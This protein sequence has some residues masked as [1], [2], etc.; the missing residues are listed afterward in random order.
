MVVDR[1]HRPHLLGTRG[2]EHRLVGIG[3]EGAPAA[4]VAHRPPELPRGRP[5]AGLHADRVPDAVGVR[6]REVA[7]GGRR[8]R[9]EAHPFQSDRLEQP[10]ADVVLV[11]HT[12]DALDDDAE[13]RVREVG[14]VEP[15]A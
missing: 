8:L 13:E 15:G 7:L 4:D 9:L 10:L 12:R 6:L 14:V 2:G 3:E 1:L 11:G 5:R